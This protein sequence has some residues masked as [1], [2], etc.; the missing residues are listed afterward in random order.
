M[1]SNQLDKFVHAAG[2]QGITRE[3]VQ[4][5]E[6]PYPL[7]DIRDKTDVFNDDRGLIGKET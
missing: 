3:L 4:A 2:A 7:P 1:S 6:L 5:I